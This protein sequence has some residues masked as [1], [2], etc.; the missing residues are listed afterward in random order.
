VTKRKTREYGDFYFPKIAPKRS[1]SNFKAQ[2]F[3]ILEQRE[4]KLEVNIQKARTSVLD[5]LISFEG[6][7]NGFSKDS[8][9]LRNL[10]R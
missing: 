8:D 1:K 10:N 9:K 7:I 6:E 2:Q 3:S 5:A 4:L